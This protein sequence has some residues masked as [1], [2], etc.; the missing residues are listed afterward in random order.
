MYASIAVVCIYVNCVV[1]DLTLKNH[2]LKDEKRNQE[3]ETAITTLA[4]EDSFV[5]PKKA[6]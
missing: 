5:Y 6:G 2:F 4:N 1:H 3:T